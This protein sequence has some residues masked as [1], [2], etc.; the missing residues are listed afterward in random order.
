MY[1]SLVVRLL[2]ACAENASADFLQIWWDASIAPGRAEQ[3]RL[4]TS[5]LCQTS[6]ILNRK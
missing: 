1:V 4:S 2:V 3:S 5:R 6:T